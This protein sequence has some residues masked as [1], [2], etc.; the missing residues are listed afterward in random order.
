MT[1]QQLEIAKM[2]TQLTVALLQSGQFDQ[3]AS[4]IRVGTKQA[5]PLL[6]VFDAIFAHLEGKTVA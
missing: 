3:F 4:D 1:D 2:A 5:P 6:Q